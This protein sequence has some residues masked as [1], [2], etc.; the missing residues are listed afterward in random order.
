MSRSV[1]LLA[2]LLA[3]SFPA[4][5]SAG[6]ETDL[7]PIRAEEVKCEPVKP[8]V[9]RGL[10]VRAALGPAFW[11]GEVGKDTRPGFAFTF[12]AGYEFTSWLALELSWSSGA[13]DTDQPAPPAPGSFS[14]HAVHGGL[15][16]GVPVGSLDLFLRGGA[17]WMW[18]RP[19]ILVRV[20]KFDGQVR[21]GWLGGA[22]VTWHTPRRH[23]WVGLEGNVL[24]AVDFPGM[25]ILAGVVIGVTL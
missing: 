15:R 11:I 25:L 12:G 2:L 4:V 10:A 5:S 6:T 24:G 22:G 8:K 1:A 3:A 18:S 13:H 7:A 21:I 9:L 17:G 20:E 16:L 23:V 14:T 19:N